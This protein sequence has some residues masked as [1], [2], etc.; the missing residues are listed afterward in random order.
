VDQPTY[1][2]RLS[3]PVSWWPLTLG[4]VVAFAL[5]APRGVAVH[6]VNV[7]AWEIGLLLGLGLPVL[8]FLLGT[9][10]T[11]VV[12]TDGRLVAGGAAVAVAA[13]GPVTPVDRTALRRLLG[14]GADPRA[15]VVYRGWVRTAVVA[16]VVDPAA[17]AAPYWL[18]STRHPDRLAA[19]IEAARA[20]VV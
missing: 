13:L 8:A 17:G 18:V 1:A 5:I 19:A 3:A 14:P 2:E 10:R 4:V 11:R 7:T 12:V 20:A 9:G 6:G 15:H 16:D